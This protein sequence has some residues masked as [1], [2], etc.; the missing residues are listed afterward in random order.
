MIGGNGKLSFGD[1]LSKNYTNKGMGGI[2][3][4]LLTSS[5]IYLTSYGWAYAIFCV[6]LVIALALYIDVLIY[7]R[8]QKELLPQ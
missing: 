2:I 5:I 4:G 6:C 7:L 8:K 1:Y 3:I